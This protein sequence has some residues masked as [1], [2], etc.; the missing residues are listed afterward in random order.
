MNTCNRPDTHPLNNRLAVLLFLALFCV[1]WT[2]VV[3]AA[4]SITVT[5]V[6][7]S[8]AGTL[9]EALSRA[10]DGDT[11]DASTVSGTI[12]LT[13]GELLVTNSVTIVGPGPGTLAVDGHSVGHVFHAK[14]NVVVRIESLTITNGHATRQQRGHRRV[15]FGGGIY[16][17]HASFT[18]S[19]CIL[20]GNKAPYG[21][22][23]Y[24]DGGLFTI[25]TSTLSSNK[26]SFGG[27][28][29]VNGGTLA[30]HN[31]VLSNNAASDFGGGVYSRVGANGSA[32][33]QIDT[34]R[35]GSNKAPNGGAVYV[36]GGT[37]TLDTSTLSGNKAGFG[38]AVYVNGGILTIQN[39]TLNQNS[40]RYFGGGILN[41]GGLNG[42]ATLR[43]YNSTLSGN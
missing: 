22:A 16:S 31:S 39:S 43:I 36:K 1:A 37:F 28:V 42:S 14:S 30:V 4:T 15:P 18:I 10:A 29:Y 13:G 41:R 33:L 3:H 26:A 32:T 17:D 34:S 2:S 7:D 12:L 40:A 20:S 6:G 8:G 35:L 24:V 23:V 21:G 5:S 11:I 25:D 9:R 38:A 27:A 19:N